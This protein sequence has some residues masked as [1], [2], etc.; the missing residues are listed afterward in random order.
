VSEV[1]GEPGRTMGQLN[2]AGVIA[3][4][5]DCVQLLNDD[6]IV[7]TKN[8]DEQIRRCVAMW[9]DGIV[10]VHVNDLLM[11]DNLCTFPLIT[12]SYLN[13]VGELCPAELRRYR[14]D[15]H[16]EDPFNLLA[17][18]GV[19]R[20]MW[21]PDVIFEHDNGTLMSEGHKEYHADADILAHDAPLYLARF[22]QRKQFALHLL[23]RIA[24]EKMRDAEL[25]F[26]K[27]QDPFTLRPTGRQ[28]RMF[29]SWM[30]CVRTIGQETTRAALRPLKRWIKGAMRM[31][32]SAR[33]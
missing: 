28:R 19:R 1:I 32:L 16:I 22:E 11:R 27:L 9:P 26:E 17:H 14:I 23:Q 15:D 13:L 21:L 12:R 29:A 31:T 2:N 3:S 30:S 6:V 5:G 25:T 18:V 33:Q 4:H 10:L 20:T 24:P 7:R 8:W